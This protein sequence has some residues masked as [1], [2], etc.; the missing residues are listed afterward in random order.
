MH[1]AEPCIMHRANGCFAARRRAIAREV[2]FAVGAG[3][4]WIVRCQEPHDPGDLCGSA[5]LMRMLEAELFHSRSQGGGPD[6]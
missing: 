3:T 6:A 2:G 4:V 1:P 5:S